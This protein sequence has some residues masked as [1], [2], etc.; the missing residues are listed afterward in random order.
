MI[1]ANKIILVIL[2]CF[3][4]SMQ[5]S[6]QDVVRFGLGTAFS[7][8]TKFIQTISLDFNRTENVKEKAGNSIIYKSN[9][10][11][12]TPT[13]DV[14]LGEGINS[15]ENNLL[16]QLSFGKVF[17]GEL[18]NL[19]LKQKQFNQTIEF[20]PSY[21]ANKTFAEK[22][23]FGQLAY[24]INFIQSKF[25]G[26]QESQDYVKNG[27]LLSISPQLNV[28]VRESSS[29][30]N[31]VLYA[32]TGLRTSL[33]YRLLSLNNKK[34][35]YED[36]VFTLN[37]LGSLIISELDSLFD[38]DFAGKFSISIDKHILPNTK[39]NLTYKVGNESPTYNKYNSLDFGVKVNY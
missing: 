22:L 7:D 15:A 25:T 12:F 18:K 23:I 3:L 8:S 19:N 34:E 11:Y 39:L 24:K 26:G 17:L 10:F 33:K 16:F 2:F 38:E 27:F 13:S 29:E 14:N 28:G 31:S 6:C 30:D 20:N 4:F 35:V 36:L 5:G 21:N 32:T 9:G 37:A 1:K